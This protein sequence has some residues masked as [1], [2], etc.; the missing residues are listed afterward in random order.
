MNTVIL[1]LRGLLPMVMI[2]NKDEQNMGTRPM[3]GSSWLEIRPQG[4]RRA[5]AGM[6]AKM[7]MRRSWRW[8]SIV[9]VSWAVAVKRRLKGSVAAVEISIRWEMCGILDTRVVVSG[10]HQR[11]ERALVCR[12]MSSFSLMFRLQDSQKPMLDPPLFLRLDRQT[13]LTLITL[14]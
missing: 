3:A 6:K 9:G 8:R 4:R 14:Y 12:F 13:I 7:E 5:R 1:S 10:S 2:W 11:F